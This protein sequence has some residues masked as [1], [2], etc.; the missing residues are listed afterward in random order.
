LTKGDFRDIIKENN[1]KTPSL[2]DDFVLRTQKVP[3]SPFG[4]NALCF[5]GTEGKN[6]G[7][8]SE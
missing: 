4:A 7:F 3:F 6:T 2:S 8:Y 1:P 5:D